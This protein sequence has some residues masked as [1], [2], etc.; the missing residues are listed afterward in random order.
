[1]SGGLS[2]NALIFRFVPAVIGSTV[3]FGMFS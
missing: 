2:A 1:M 3:S